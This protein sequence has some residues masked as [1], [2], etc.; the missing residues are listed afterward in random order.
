MSSS[1]RFVS[2]GSLHV[3]RAG[4]CGMYFGDTLD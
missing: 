4:K 1:L 3:Y 2:T